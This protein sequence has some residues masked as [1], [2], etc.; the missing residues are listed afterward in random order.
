MAVADFFHCDGIAFSAVESPRFIAMCKAL[1][2][3]ADDFKLPHRHK[4]GKELLDVNFNSCC[5]S[6]NKELMKD[7]FVFGSTFLGDG[8]TIGQMPLVNIL[9]I[10]AEVPPVVI[11]IDGFTGKYTNIS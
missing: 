4:L 7:G 10:V 8:A 3:V 11:A 6:N 1:R 5:E 9:G 2:F